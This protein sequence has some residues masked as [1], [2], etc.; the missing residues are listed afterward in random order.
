MAAAKK[1]KV[2]A[3]AVTDSD[4]VRYEVEFTPDKPEMSEGTSTTV[5]MP[6]GLREVVIDDPLAWHKAMG[7]FSH[8]TEKE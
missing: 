1:Q 2:K 8:R 6:D 5:D 3:F 4:G 7:R